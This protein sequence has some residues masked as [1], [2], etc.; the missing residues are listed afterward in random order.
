MLPIP[1]FLIAADIQMASKLWLKFN[2]PLSIIHESTL[3]KPQVFPQSKLEDI[4]WADWTLSK[5]LIS[6]LLYKDLHPHKYLI[7][8]L[9]SLPPQLHK[10]TFSQ[11]M[12]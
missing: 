2:S 8:Q 6:Y 11:Q 9:S 5:N 4:I 3:E 7:S 10:N 1:N 12:F